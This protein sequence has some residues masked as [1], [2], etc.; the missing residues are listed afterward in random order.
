MKC[1]KQRGKLYEIWVDELNPKDPH[2]LDVIYDSYEIGKARAKGFKEAC[3][4]FF[5]ASGWMEK[6]YDEKNMT[7]QNRKLFE[8]EVKKEG[9]ENE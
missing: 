1:K 8:E 5:K 7:W 2:D 3:N 9:K 4:K 6:Y